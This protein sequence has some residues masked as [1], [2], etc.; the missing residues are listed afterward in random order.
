MAQMMPVMCNVPATHALNGS[1]R[2]HETEIVLESFNVPATDVAIHAGVSLLFFVT[3]NVRWSCDCH[4]NAREGAPRAAQAPVFH[5][6]RELSR[7]C[8]PHCPNQRRSRLPCVGELEIVRLSLQARAWTH[9]A[10][11][12][13]FH[14]H[15]HHE[16]SCWVG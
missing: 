12:S 2:E 13:S 7:R 4:N 11:V 14:R 10:Q 3:H 5:V 9:A 16:F 1:D 15:A 8:V 6:K